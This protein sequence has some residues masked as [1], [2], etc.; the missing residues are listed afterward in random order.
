MLEYYAADAGVEDAMWR[1]RN[2]KLPDWM[3]GN[4]GEATYKHDP[5]GYSLPTKINN[6]DVEVTIKPLW[7]LEGLETPSPGQGREPHDSLVTVSNVIGEIDKGNGLY[8]GLYQINIIYDG[9]VGKLKI[10]RIGVWLPPGFGYVDYSSNLESE[11]QTFPY[12]GG[13]AI[14]WDYHPAIDY[15]KL[16]GPGSKRVVTFE[17]T[18]NE[19]PEVAFAWI[20]T[21]RMDIYLSWDIYPSLGMDSK[22]YRITSKAT[23]PVSKKYTTVTAY[24]TKTM[25]GDYQATG[26]TLMRD[27]DKDKPHYYRERLYKETSATINNIPPDAKV[28]RIFLYWSGWKNHLWDVSTLSEEKRQ[29]LPSDYKVNQITL[30][31]EI[32]GVKFPKPEEVTAWVTQV[33]P[34]VDSDNPNGWSY[35]CFADVTKLVTEF[36]EKKKLNFIGN[37]TYTVG[38]WDVKKTKHGDYKYALYEWKDDHSGETIVGY[39]RYPLGSYLGQNDSGGDEWAYAGWSVIVIYSSSSTEGRYLYI[40]DEFRTVLKDKPLEFTIMGFRTP[41][42]VGEEAARL[43]AFVGEGDYHEEGD[44]IRVNNKPLSDLINPDNNVWN[45]KSKLLDDTEIEGIDIDTFIISGAIIESGDTNAEVKL[46]TESDSWNL[47]YIIL[48]FRDEI[49][50]TKILSYQVKIGEE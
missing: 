11:P 21:N 10:E 49:I 9:S 46:L 50:P 25:K 24:T 45:S 41:Q 12:N 8:H 43:T 28:E 47:I 31:V 33:L 2:D 14:T 42:D 29:S 6:K 38:H 48:S 19:N 34:N 36:F 26:N 35:S 17:F 4:W 15:D 1:I 5:Y 22:I 40:Y 37:A 16:P 7:L 23:D 27:H 39:T 20:R 18:P 3:L 30:Q 44:S 32:G 13:T